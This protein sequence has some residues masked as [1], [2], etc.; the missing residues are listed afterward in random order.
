MGDRYSKHRDGCL[1][2]RT[3][4]RRR[5][6]RGRGGGR[7]TISRRIVVLFHY[8]IG[9]RAAPEL[10]GGAG[11]PQAQVPAP[12]EGA[13]K[14]RHAVRRR[15]LRDSTAGGRDLGAE[16]DR[17]DGVLSPEDDDRVRLERL[18]RLHREG[19]TPPASPRRGRDRPQGRNEH[20]TTTSWCIYIYI[21]TTT[22]STPSLL[23]NLLLLQKL[24]PPPDPQLRRP[25]FV[26]PQE[27]RSWL[28]GESAN[29]INP[30]PRAR[31]RAQNKNC[32]TY[33]P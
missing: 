12:A 10:P 4:R 7:R 26:A 20:C 2:R 16:R 28:H 19:G 3:R 31:A 1:R 32:V 18:S 29:M 14:G 27:K 15:N 9:G 6:G 17:G 8:R 23:S 5:D 21:Y 25:V 22:S 30:L 24:R 11:G 13:G 33:P